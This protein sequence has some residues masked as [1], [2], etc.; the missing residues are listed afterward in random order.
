MNE[1]A[2]SKKDDRSDL[3]KE[4]PNHDNNGWRSNHFRDDDEL[5][6]IRN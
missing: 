1:D 2:G 6:N 5:S 3:G 4:N